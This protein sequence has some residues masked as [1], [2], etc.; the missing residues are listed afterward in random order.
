MSN[1]KQYFDHLE[2]SE[3]CIWAVDDVEGKKTP[4]KI[5]NVSYY[6]E[7]NN[8]ESPKFLFELREE[9]GGVWY[10]RE[11]FDS[12]EKVRGYSEEI[13]NMY[14]KIDAKKF[15]CFMKNRRL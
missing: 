1:E 5:L 15:I 6:Q 11:K 7:L 9:L 3:G 8:Q 4:L 10:S 14:R 2:E 13:L 12:E